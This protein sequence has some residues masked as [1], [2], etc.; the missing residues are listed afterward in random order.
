MR[1]R[2]LVALALGAAGCIPIPPHHFGDTRAN[3]G[4]DSTA[5]IVTGQTTQADAIFRFSEPDGAIDNDHTLWWV[6]LDSRGGGF[7]L[8]PFSTA[9]GVAVG[10]D[11]RRLRRLVTWFGEDGRALGSSLQIG[12][13]HVISYVV[14]VHEGRSA[15][16]CLESLP[17]RPKPA[18][19]TA[20]PRNDSGQEGL[21]RGGTT[22]GFSK[23][24]REPPDDQ[25]PK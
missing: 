6:S 17:P 14:A 22:E 18:P 24:A 23:T 19:S 20:P 16:E 5:A 4:D 21:L 13:C 15:T 25:T 3:I 9:A 2:I 10:G 1:R 12:N 11:A 7:L 8:I